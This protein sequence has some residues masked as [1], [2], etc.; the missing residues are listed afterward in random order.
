MSFAAVGPRFGVNK[1]TVRYIRKNE[2]SVSDSVA[3][4]ASASIEVAHKVHGKCIVKIEKALNMW[5][6]DKHRKN[7]PTDGNVIRE[8]AKSLYA[9]FME[10]AGREG[11]SATPSLAFR[12]IKS[13][14][15]NLKKILAPRCK[16]DGDGSVSGPLCRGSIFGARQ[17]A[18]KG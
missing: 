17:E 10:S 14:F 9:H 3:A 16:A 11:T 4:S 5:I 1:S 12:R 8:K 13:W 6:E 18:D 2:T 7:V 15:H